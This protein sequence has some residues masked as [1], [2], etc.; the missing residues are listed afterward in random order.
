MRPGL[1]FGCLLLAFGIGFAVEPTPD[2]VLAAVE[3]GD[4]SALRER[5]KAR[6]K[7][8]KGIVRTRLERLQG[9]LSR[10]DYTNGWSVYVNRGEQ[11]ARLDGIAVEPKDF[12]VRPLRSIPEPRFSPAD[13]PNR[14]QLRYTQSEGFANDPNG[15]VYYR[16]EWHLFHQHNPYGLWF[17]NMTWDHAVSKDL[18]HW[19]ELGGVLDPDGMG[20]M[21]SGS[22]V[23]DEHNVAGFGN[24]A[25]VL[26]YTACGYYMAQCLASS[27]DGRVF[28]KWNG[29]PAINFFAGGNR[30]PKAFWHEPTKRWVIPVYA[31]NEGK[32]AVW[33]F[34]SP[35]LR[36]WKQ[37]SV[38]DGD[39]VKGGGKF[40]YECP[41]LERI[42]IEGE[43]GAAWVLWGADGDYVTG[44]F[45]GR[46][47]VQTGARKKG[48]S[49]PRMGYY[50]AQTFS[51]VPDGRCVW[52]AC[53]LADYSEG[54]T[55]HRTFSIP[56]ELTLRRVGGDL[57]LV[58]RPVREY[59][60]LRRDEALPLERFD[61]EL[62]EIH[63]K[64]KVSA[65]GRLTFDLRG[66]NLSYD[67]ETGELTMAKTVSPWKLTDGCLDLVVYLDR[68][69]AEVFS[70]D[71]LQVLP[72]PDS[73]PDL[74]N[75]KLSVKS[76]EGVTVQKFVAFGLK[77]IYAA[78]LKSAEMP[79]AKK[80]EEK[81]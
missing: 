39:E 79:T 38:F 45:D 77:S 43:E 16:G 61:G 66:V 23:V 41:G 70:A 62:A 72:V 78:E 52:L 55:F 35:N 29:N 12:F 80:Q 54:A 59:R 60:S 13:D 67:G 49:G 4:T 28:T 76:A 58:R 3:S 1:L 34:S 56:Q 46:R 27:T 17:G 15:L 71:G 81:R 26:L 75:R 47:F 6:L 51:N 65:R 68:V 64:A 40:L 20:V 8:L 42:P 18:V 36:E 11:V 31:E 48:I 63:L 57:L 32:H 50:A 53:F 14:P 24:N 19:K 10:I 5:D 73:R 69:T 22:A 25:L 33:I 2:A 44:E 21:Y 7:V 37:E 74:K 9:G 30:D